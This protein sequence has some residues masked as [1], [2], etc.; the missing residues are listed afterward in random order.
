MVVNYRMTLN[1]VMAD[2]RSCGYSISQKTLSDGM[3]AGAFPFGK[4]LSTGE[5]GRRTFI[6]LRREYEIWKNETMRGN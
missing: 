6:I 2:M 5:T 4:L 3:A 1:E